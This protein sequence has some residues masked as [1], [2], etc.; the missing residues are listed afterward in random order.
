MSQRKPIHLE[1]GSAEHEIAG[2]GVIGS[3][4]AQPLPRADTTKL[5]NQAEAIPK[6]MYEPIAIVATAC[7]FPSAPNI[8]TFWANLLRGAKAERSRAGA[9]LFD[10]EFF[11]LGPWE[12]KL[13]DPQ[14]RIFL[15]C[16]WEA[17]ED[18]GHDLTGSAEPVGVF[19]AS[20]VNPYLSELI[21]L[22]ATGHD[23]DLRFA[24]ESSRDNLANRVCHH[25]N[26]RGPAMN[27]HAGGASSL[28][29][30]ATACKSLLNFECD[31]ALAGAVAIGE[32]VGAGVLV[33]RRLHDAVADR[34]HIRA[35]ISATAINHN[36]KQ[37]PYGQPDLEA[38]AEVIALAQA[39]AG[40]SPESI[41]FVEMN[42]MGAPSAD[43]V[44]IGALMRV[45]QD[46][47]AGAPWCALGSVKGNVGDLDVASGI[48]AIMKSVLAIEHRQLPPVIGFGERALALAERP[49]YVNATVKHWPEGPTPCRAGVSSF[50]LGGSNVHIILQEAPRL[51][52]NQSWQGPKLLVLSAK[53]PARLQAFALRMAEFLQTAADLNDISYTLQAGRKHFEWRSTVVCTDR[54]NAIR[55]LRGHQGAVRANLHDW[56]R[57]RPVFLF[58]GLGNQYSGMAAHLYK[59]EPFFARQIDLCCEGLKSILEADLR[60]TI[61]APIPEKIATPSASI[62]FARMVSPP[63][64]TV[65][66]DGPEVAQPALFVVEYALGRLLQH[67]GVEPSAMAGYSIGEYVAACLA[68]V[69]SIEDALRIVAHRSLLARSLPESRMLAVPLSAEE[70]TALIN[71]DIYLCGIHGPQLCLLG[72]TDSAMMDL[73]SSLSAKGIVSRRLKSTRAFHSK[74]MEPIA[75]ALHELLA[76]VRLREPVI[77]Y[78]SNLTGNWIKPGQATNPRYW[79]SHLCSPVRFSPGI[80]TIGETGRRLFVEVGPG[81]SLSGLAMAELVANGVGDS[82]FVPTLPSMYDNARDDEALTHTIAELWKHGVEFDWDSIHEG[83]NSQRVSLP[84]TCFERQSYWLTPTYGKKLRTSVQSDEASIA[85]NDARQGFAEPTNIQRSVE[86]FH[87]SAGTHNAVPDTDGQGKS[88]AELTTL[89]ATA[90]S[91]AVW[92]SEKFNH[93]PIGLDDDFFDL[94]GDSLIAMQIL[95]RVRHEM[96]VRVELRSFLASPTVA[97]LAEH[98]DRLLQAAGKADHEDSGRRG[99]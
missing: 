75:A 80:K 78:V 24:I 91:L 39:L 33:L 65:E 63:E 34:D 13:L 9:E 29:T 83:R 21:S 51:P 27:I 57:C 59:T 53:S 12:A 79:T 86:V 41:H 47:S 73:Q 42:R 38:Q 8:E 71:D 4:V 44:E 36:G 67:W 70:A 15:E 3:G 1:K 76:E 68:E 40:V 64:E 87:A 58:P 81:R 10:A 77:P 32:A 66:S 97:G 89:A 54:E 69:F 95:N 84:G 74:L 37:Q 98:I 88:E 26:L 5:E 92:W 2:S 85:T 90:R 56:S 60:Q 49:F 93:A 82:A 35:L 19:C 52:K 62:D 28:A 30:I 99:I 55:Q 72:G 31:F 16:A 20:G 94:G 45:F 50:S 23:A 11:D 46:R 61:L 43:E 17:M 96:G 22:G 25:L 18:S 48:A 14:Q 7:R 6:D